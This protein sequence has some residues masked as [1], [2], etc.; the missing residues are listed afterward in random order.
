MSQQNS[1]MS[2]LQQ[3]HGREKEKAK[4]YRLKYQ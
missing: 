1:V 2:S 3:A 4:F